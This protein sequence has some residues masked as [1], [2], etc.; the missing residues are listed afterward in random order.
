MI[1][2]IEG[3]VT[4]TRRSHRN[5]L[6]TRAIESLAAGW[7][8]V[9]KIAAISGALGLAGLFLWNV[10]LF[11]EQSGN[12]YFTNENNGTITGS[13]YH[14]GWGYGWTAFWFL[15]ITWTVLAMVITARRRRDYHDR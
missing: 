12:I 10:Y 15:L 6:A 4:C 3:C 14:Q 1:K 7:V 5:D 13:I 8:R 2:E 9:T 11:F